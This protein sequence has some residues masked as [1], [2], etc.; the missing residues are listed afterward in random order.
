LQ[1]GAILYW[2][3]FWL[4]ENNKPILEEEVA[5]FLMVSGYCNLLTAM[6]VGAKYTGQG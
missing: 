6:L 5:I 1:T 2:I 3:I 4:S